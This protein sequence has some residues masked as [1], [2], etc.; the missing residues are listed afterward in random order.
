MPY[1]DLIKRKKFHK[2]YYLKHDGLNRKRRP[3]GK[4][5]TQEDILKYK[6]TLAIVC[7]EY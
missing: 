5:Q 2:Q 6:R 4:Q 3:K 1:K 7:Q